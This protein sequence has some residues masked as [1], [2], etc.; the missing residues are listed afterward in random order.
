MDNTIK[1]EVKTH[2]GRDLIYPLDHAKEIEIL[3]GQKTLTDKNIS[4]LKGLGF[5]FEIVNNKTI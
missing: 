4:A 5:T 2:Y 1:V 3:T